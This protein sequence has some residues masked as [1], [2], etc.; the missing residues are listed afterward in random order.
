MEPARPPACLPAGMQAS[1]G[2]DSAATGQVGP[3]GFHTCLPVDVVNAGPSQLRQVGRRE[4]EGRPAG[5]VVTSIRRP[6]QGVGLACPDLHC[7]LLPYRTM[8]QVSQQAV[9]L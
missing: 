6:M 2:S 9:L 1:C 7:Q 5:L 4:S 3:A 8:R